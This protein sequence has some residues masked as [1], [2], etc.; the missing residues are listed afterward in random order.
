MGGID[1]SAMMKQAFKNMGIDPNSVRIVQGASSSSFGSKPSTQFCKLS[2]VAPEPASEWDIRELSTSDFELRGARAINRAGS[3]VGT[4][5]PIGNPAICVPWLLRPN[6]TAITLGY[7]GIAAGLN[8]DHE[9]VGTSRDDPKSERAVRWEEKRGAL[10]LGLYAGGA[11]AVASTDSG[12]LGINDAAEIIGSIRNR[13]LEQ[14][15]AHLR[16]AVFRRKGSI[17]VFS[18]GPAPFDSRPIALTH[19]GLVLIVACLGP[20]NV[21]SIL[22]DPTSDSWEYVGQDAN[23][24][25]FPVGINDD[26]LVLGQARD[27]EGSPIAAVASSKQGWQAIGTQ[28]GWPPTGMNNR[29]E[30]VGWGKMNGLQRPWIRLGSG[31][32][33]PLP[34]A[35][36]HH[37]TPTAINDRG[38]IVGGAGSDHGSHVVVWNR[39]P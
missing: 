14:G 5:C 8:N 38:D 12:A 33:M 27:K 15:R 21:R 30:I 6:G 18:H 9:V 39:A 22:W 7:T 16:T 35:R 31:E 3:I 23:A 26:G 17:D 11:E 34:Y 25:V 4:G 24:N 1:M 36:E 32:I 28:N 2:F 37:T 19:G 20:F 10:D 29:G 13:A